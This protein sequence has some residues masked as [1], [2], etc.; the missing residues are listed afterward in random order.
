MREADNVD[1]PMLL[2][3]FKLRKADIIMNKGLQDQ[4]LAFSA[5]DGV[6]LVG[7]ELA[8]PDMVRDMHTHRYQARMLRET[9]TDL[10]V[11]K[12]C[13]Y[14]AHVRMSCFCTHMH[15]VPARGMHACTVLGS[16]LSAGM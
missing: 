11:Y 3:K 13:V 7:Q 9:H 16:S 10:L 5:K 8:I 6:K 1:L 15:S 2:D 4:N 12:V 14:R